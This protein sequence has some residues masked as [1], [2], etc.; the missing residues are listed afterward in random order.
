MA[1]K[2]ARRGYVIETGKVALEGESD[3]ILNND[4]VRRLYLGG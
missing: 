2:L 1:L 3:K 4:D